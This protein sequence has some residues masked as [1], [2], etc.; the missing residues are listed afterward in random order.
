MGTLYPACPRAGD[1]MVPAM[2][3]DPRAESCSSQE[4]LGELGGALPSHTDTD[5]CLWWQSQSQYF[6]REKNPFLSCKGMRVLG[7]RSSHLWGQHP[8]GHCYWGV[9]RPIQA[10]QGLQA[11]GV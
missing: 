5:P 8:Q 10:L 9:S 4:P 11:G 2:R 6:N 3:M 7:K 1:S